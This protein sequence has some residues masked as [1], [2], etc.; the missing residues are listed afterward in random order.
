MTKAD[1]AK[2]WALSR[3]GCPYIY[4]G[5]GQICTPSY[6]EARAA[7]YPNYAVKIR[8][9]CP[10]L[11][12]NTTSC[13]DCEWCDPDTNQGKRAYDCAQ[14]VRRCMEHI[15]ISMVSGANS[16]WTQTNWE[17]AG[18]IGSVPKNKLCVLYRYDDDKKRMG[19]TGLYLGDGWIVHAKGHDYGVVRELLGNPTFTHW[20]IPMGL[21]SEIRPEDVLLRNG[22]TGDA[23]KELQKRLN[24]NGYTLDVD[25]KFGK[26][27]EEAVRAFQKKN[28]LKVDGI[29]GP[30]T[31]AALGGSQE[32]TSTGDNDSGKNNSAE[33]DA[34]SSLLGDNY[35]VL[36]MSDALRL[37]DAVNTIENILNQVNWG[38]N[39]GQGDAE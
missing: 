38:D 11:S 27:T 19:H 18:E 14:L 22:N 21:Y 32:N 6:R 28:G 4:G 30:K 36:S 29:V 35:F 1:E 5:T 12:G 10:R 23:V 2:A 9:N 24:A 13:T 34:P 37:R 3:V 33:S 31:W 15:G 20:G 17:S 39:Y 7:Q 8:K 16:Q 25:G 26:K